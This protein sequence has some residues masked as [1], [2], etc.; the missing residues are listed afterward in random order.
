MKNLYDLIIIGSGCA[1]MS[2]GIYAG[3]SMLKTLIIEKDRAG[4]QIKITSEVENYPGIL[5]TSGENLSQTMRRQIGRAH[6]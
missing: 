4:G 6:V 1:G 3:R 2:A 5:H